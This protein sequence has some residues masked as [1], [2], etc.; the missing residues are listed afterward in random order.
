[1]RATNRLTRA[2]SG[3]VWATSTP[4]ERT[5]LAFALH[6][7]LEHPTTKATR[8]LFDWEREHYRALPPPP[9]RVLVGA[10]GSG[11][12]VLVLLERGYQV[13]AFEPADEAWAALRENAKGR[14]TLWQLRYEDLVD[15]VETG[16]A[17]GP[18]PERYDA[19]LLGWGSLA[20]IIEDDTRHRLIRACDALC[21]RGPILAST[22]LRNETARSGMGR[23]GAIASRWMGESAPHQS[24]IFVPSGGF[25]HPLTRSE[26]EALGSEVG[27][28]T[29]WGETSGAYPH[30]TWVR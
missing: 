8:G 14:A 3:I 25:M 21:P 19:V 7:A 2:L 16:A 20:C 17:T 10:A 30:F 29:V 12:E 23:A 15:R 24:M 27:R 18:Q 13:D 4:S 26:V 22:F 1:M 5:E 6:D 11:R 28:R 9:A